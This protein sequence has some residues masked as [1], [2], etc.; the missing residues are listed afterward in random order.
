MV[1]DK[2]S[3][4]CPLACI[5]AFTHA[6]LHI[7][8]HICID[9]IF[10]QLTGKIDRFLQRRGSRKQSSSGSTKAFYSI[11]LYHCSFF[12]IVRAL[13]TSGYTPCQ[14]LDQGFRLIKSTQPVLCHC[15]PNSKTMIQALFCYHRLLVCIKN[16]SKL[17]LV[18]K[19]SCPS[20]LGGSW[21]A[22]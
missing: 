17:G 2:N 4:S 16:S 15:F 21:A 10:L 6:F 13:R 11:Q 9:A 12:L 3:H 8:I 19:T 7:Y 22:E 14:I 20:Y 5:V 1:E 18:M